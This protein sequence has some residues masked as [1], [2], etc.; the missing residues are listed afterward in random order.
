MLLQEKNVP[1]FPAT[2]NGIYFG[3]NRFRNKYPF[4]VDDSIVTF[5]LRNNKNASHVM[6]AGSFNNWD[7]NIL[8][9]H[10]ADSGWIAFVKLGAGKYWYKFIADGN[11]MPDNDNQLKENDGLGN[12][13]SVYFKPNVVFNL[14]GF[15]NAK[16]VFLAGS[17]NNWKPNGLP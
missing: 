15:T 12:I 5:F 17:F 2:D 6:L 1:L 7:P 10:F 11:W 8:S 16:K 4:A 9:M 14:N 3:V 13:N